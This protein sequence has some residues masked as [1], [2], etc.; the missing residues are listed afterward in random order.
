MT[1]YWGKKGAG[2]DARA[3]STESPSDDAEPNPPV[4]EQEA[5]LDQLAAILRIWG[6]HAFDLDDLNAPTIRQQF[7]LWARHALVLAAT[8][9]SRP[10]SPDEAEPAAPPR[11]DWQGLR[12][13]VT[14]L[15]RREQAYVARQIRDTRQVI[16]DFVQTLVGILA[17]DQE[18]QTRV[19]AVVN[20]L[21]QAID[22]NAPLEVLTQEAMRAINLISRIAEER[23]QRHQNLFQDLTGKLQT[24][25]GELDEA[26][27]E[28]ELDPLTRLY[29]RKAFDEHLERV[30][31]LSMLSGQPACLL[32]LDVDHFKDVNDRFG[33][34]VGDLVLKRLADC[35]LHAFPR[36]A[37][38][39]ARYGG[40]EFI[41]ILQ[42][43]PLR[44]ATVLGERLLRAIRELR[45]E[46]DRGTVN[47]T[48][49][50]GLA[51]L[52]PRASPG[53]WLR[54]ADSALYRAKRQGRDR[55]ECQMAES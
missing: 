53:Q 50:I 3:G 23:N 25:R 37:D 30:F 18:E 13:F 49:S 35:C 48:A 6:R 46:H 16:G 52:D 7:E 51:E 40:E 5:A 12:D 54:G 33:H 34:P 32:M 28:M 43:T 2:I 26:R 14:R 44:T 39:V 45:V 8:P 36:K 27:R 10:E 20:N 47:F 29:N 38:F 22:G 4:L 31:E 17:E 55:I 11:R 15:R 19:T 42:E 1:K 21:R 41:I 9:A 24:L